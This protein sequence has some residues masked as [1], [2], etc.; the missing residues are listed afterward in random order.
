MAETNT[1]TDYKIRLELDLDSVAWPTVLKV[2][3]DKFKLTFQQANQSISDFTRRFRD[4]LNLSWF[5]RKE[6]SSEEGK[7]LAAVCEVHGADA[8]SISSS[9]R[10]ICGWP[11]FILRQQVEFYPSFRQSEQ[12]KKGGY[13]VAQHTVNIFGRNIKIEKLWQAL[14]AHS[15]FISLAVLSFVLVVGCLLYGL[16]VFLLFLIEPAFVTLAATN[17][18]TLGLALICVLVGMA[19]IFGRALQNLYKLARSTLIGRHPSR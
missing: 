10:L 16:S 2:L 3:C 17:S 8:V 1:D 18:A 13:L 7:L 9:R 19:G 15:I 4:T 5:L 6:L 11:S 12:S 14:I